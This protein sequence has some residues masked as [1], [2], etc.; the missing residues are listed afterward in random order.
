MASRRLLLIDNVD[1]EGAVSETAA[2]SLLVLRGGQWLRPQS[3]F[4]LSGITV[5]K[6]DRMLEADG[7]KVVGRRVS[8]EDMLGADAVWILNS[9]AGIMPACALDGTA[10]TNGAQTL[11]RRLRPRLRE[12]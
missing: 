1:H 6:V 5:R 4:Q 12:S 11:A 2:G 3:A 7:E 9:L 8:R 10:L